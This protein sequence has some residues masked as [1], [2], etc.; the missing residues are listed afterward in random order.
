MIAGENHLYLWHVG[1]KR[2]QDKSMYI[3]HDDILRAR[4]VDLLTYLREFEPDEL[5][6]ETG[7][8]YCLKSHDSLKISNGKWNWFS[9]G[10]GGHTALDFLVKVRK[11]P[12]REAVRILNNQ[13]IYEPV[14]SE[15][16]EDKA[17]VKKKEVNL[18]KRNKSETRI[19]EYLAGRGI[20]EEIVD[21]CIQEQLIYE[22]Y[23]E[24]NVV[25][26]GYN[27]NTGKVEFAS[28]R[29]TSPQ[30]IMRDCAGSDKSYSF[31][32]IGKSTEAVHVFESA[33]D[34]LSYMTLCKNE[35]SDWEQ[36]TVL[37]L[38]GIQTTNGK[39]VPARLKR[40][41]NGRPWTKGV[42]LHLDAD[43]P[44]REAA[45]NIKEALKGK[46]PVFDLPPIYGKD[47]N[48]Y[49]VLSTSRTP[50]NERSYIR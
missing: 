48:E 40:Y 6:H 33:I 22:S 14:R 38:S 31:K 2:R 36:L 37:S 21:F 47:Y 9:Q 20:D 32:I 34:R 23:P 44:G 17:P 18:P 1:E 12:F 13:L 39:K 43:P 29:A 27:D 5:V 10:F 4:R 28:I 19:K 42:I 8:Q 45:E 30:R 16:T 26:L 25:F 15:K 7:D 41:L 3:P 49:L 11:L 35:G 50:K 46:F 24:H